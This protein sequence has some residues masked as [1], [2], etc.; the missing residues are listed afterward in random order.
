MIGRCEPR[1]AGDSQR[2]ARLLSDLEHVL[3]RFTD[4]AGNRCQFG[5]HA[6][7]PHEASS[8]YIIQIET[9]ARLTPV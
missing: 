5:L 3:R 7:T 4:R 2:V 8:S 6:P 9:E 1:G